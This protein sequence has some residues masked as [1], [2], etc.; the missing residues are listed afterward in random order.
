MNRSL[1]VI[2]AGR[3]VLLLQTSDD[4]CEGRVLLI[5]PAVPKEY[6]AGDKVKKMGVRGIKYGDNVL[7]TKEYIAREYSD[8]DPNLDEEVK[9]TLAHIDGIVGIVD[10]K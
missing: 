9:Y 3:Y 8:E 1:P 10:K 6:L 7:I 4:I 2:P 5:G